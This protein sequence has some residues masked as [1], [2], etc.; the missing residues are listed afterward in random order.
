MTEEDS[1][2]IRTDTPIDAIHALGSGIMG[3]A[4]LNR[5]DNI[6]NLAI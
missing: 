6:P 1:Y 4:R 5:R 3:L 2:T